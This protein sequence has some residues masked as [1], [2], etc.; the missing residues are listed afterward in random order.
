MHRCRE[1]L[2]LSLCV[3]PLAGIFGSYGGEQPQARSRPMTPRDSGIFDP[4]AGGFPPSRA[5]LKDA[6]RLDPSQCK[7][8]GMKKPTMEALRQRADPNRS[9]LDGGVFGSGPAEP[10]KSARGVN[11]RNASTFSF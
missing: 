8:A 1:A 3:Y 2:A 7:V 6:N 4:P 11:A 9:C 10:I 5:A